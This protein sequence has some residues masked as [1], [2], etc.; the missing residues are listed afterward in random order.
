MHVYLPAIGFQCIQKK[1][2][3]QWLL[4]EVIENADKVTKIMTDDETSLICYKQEVA[5]GIGLIVC[6]E[7]VRGYD[8]EVEYY[9][10]YIVSDVCSTE[11]ECFL[12]RQSDKHGFS[13]L[14]DDY[15]LGLN[16]IFTV[17]NFMELRKKDV[18]KQMTPDIRGVCLSGLATEGKILF[19]VE[20]PVSLET[21]KKE[22]KR[23][24]L[25]KAARNG[26]QK[27]IETLTYADMNINAKIGRYITTSDVY[28]M[29]DSYIMPQGVE[30]DH[31][32]VLGTITGFSNPVN[33]LSREELVLMDVSC[34]DVSLR[35]L[36]NQKDLLGEPATGRRFKGDV[37]L[38][39]NV[40]LS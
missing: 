24:S 14:C 13:G 38:Q 10:P 37:W 32:S 11:A 40:L 9:F 27:A 21:A 18:L 34:N 31:Y 12:E 6:G 8:F 16:L 26:D 36:V 5:P 19:P 25:L 4:S 17:T 33:E 3:L 35:I 28:S 20:K 29:V 2:Q 39:G 15:R 1:T 23:L 30:S 7:Q 22:Q